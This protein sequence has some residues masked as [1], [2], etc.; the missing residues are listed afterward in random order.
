MREHLVRAPADFLSSL[1]LSPRSLDAIVLRLAVKFLRGRAA[2]PTI[3]RQGSY[4][5]FFYASDRPEPMHVH[6]EGRGGSAKF[7]LR[8][9]RLRT[10]RGLAR[11]EL[12]RLE[13]IVV[14]RHEQFV[15]AWNEYFEG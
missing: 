9:V 11:H 8:P 4:R 13:R 5:F 1:Q 10:S 7:W 12:S 15:R 14:A 3:W 6:V 2:M